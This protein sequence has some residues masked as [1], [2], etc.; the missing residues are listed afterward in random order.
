[1]PVVVAAVHI[2][3]LILEDL[4]VVQVQ[5]QVVETVVVHQQVLQI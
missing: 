5:V 2:K 1:M 4:V 3:W